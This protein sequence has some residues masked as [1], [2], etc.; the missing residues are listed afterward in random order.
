MRELY[1]LSF[2]RLAV[3]VGWQRAEITIIKV[4]LAV[5]RILQ[6][7]KGDHFYLFV[8]PQQRIV[9]PDND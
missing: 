4:Q 3:R 6:N 9:Y 1:D 7:D 5:W 8:S 2:S